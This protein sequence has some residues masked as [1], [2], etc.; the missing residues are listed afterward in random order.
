M[1]IV[2]IQ[3]NWQLMLVRMQCWIEDFCTNPS[4]IEMNETL[5]TNQTEKK[6]KNN[7]AY[8]WYTISKCGGNI[9]YLNIIWFKISDRLWKS[10]KILCTIPNMVLIICDTSQATKAIKAVTF[11]N[12]ESGSFS[13]FTEH[14][15]ESEHSENFFLTRPSF[16]FVS[17]EQNIERKKKNEMHFGKTI[18]KEFSFHNYLCHMKLEKFCH[19]RHLLKMTN[20]QN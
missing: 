9:R 11:F 20:L 10:P 6:D 15:L 8:R 17:Y 7:K 16:V 2:E 5:T 12:L 4:R 3:S 14:I 19:E 13:V 18:I 1:A